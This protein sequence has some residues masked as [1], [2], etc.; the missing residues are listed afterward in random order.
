MRDA[1]PEGLR[2]RAEVRET[3]A[4]AVALVRVEGEVDLANADELEAE[5]FSDPCKSA[6]GIVLDLLGVPFMDSS[7]LR[8][9]LL[10]ARDAGSRLV[11]LLSPGSPVL[12]LLEFA[13]MTDIVPICSTEDEALRALTT[14]AVD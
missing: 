10:L 12:R 13:E 9:L 1:G 3:E 6:R 4:G 14:S 5:L 2:L 7:G 11:I 8:V